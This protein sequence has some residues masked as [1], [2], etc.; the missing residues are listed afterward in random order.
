[1]I[2]D[3][4][5][6]SKRFEIE[7]ARSHRPP[8]QSGI[9]FQSSQTLDDGQRLERQD[10][11]Q[12]DG[13]SFQTPNILDDRQRLEQQAMPQLGYAGYGME[14]TMDAYDG[15]RG[16]V[17]T[18]RDQ[19]SRIYSDMMD[20]REDPRQ[21]LPINR[22]ELP[23]SQGYTPGL[24]YPSH[25]LTQSVSS[26]YNDH[27]SIQPMTLGRNDTPPPRLGRGASTLYGRSYSSSISGA[28]DVPVY[29]ASPASDSVRWCASSDPP[30]SSYTNFGRPL[31]PRYAEDR[32][33]ARHPGWGDTPNFKNDTA[34]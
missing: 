17:R 18:Y 3:L 15:G 21:Q 8:G 1:M 11:P 14:M 9:S 34:R 24:A 32:T 19:Q 13:I 26:G 25:S 2:T 6:D 22:H 23:L 20:I 33:G 5:Q 30:S 28:Y 10:I 16:A 4:K 7:T 27:P 31:A 12:S 29:D